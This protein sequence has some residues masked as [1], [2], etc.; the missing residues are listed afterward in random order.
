MS[1]K[2]IIS[3]I[4]ILLF[5]AADGLAAT[6]TVT[7]TNDSGPG[8]L[9]QAVL[10]ANASNDDDTIL[11]DIPDCPNA[12]CTIELTSGELGIGPNGKLKILNHGGPD[13]LII[14]GGNLSWIFLVDQSPSFIVQGLTMQRA[15]GGQ[16]LGPFQGGA[17]ANHLGKTSVVNCRLQH[18]IGLGGG[19]ANLN[20]SLE[21]IRS[22]IINNRSLSEGG[23]IFNFDGDLTVIDSLIAENV[24]GSKSL[25]GFGGGIMI[26]AMYDFSRIVTIANTTISRNTT[27]SP[28]GGG[29]GG[30]IYLLNANSTVNLINVT[31]T[32]NSAVYGGAVA[33]DGLFGSS[34]R[35]RNSIFSGNFADSYPEISLNTVY[36]ENLGNNLL[37]GSPM[38]GQLA[39]N[40]GPTRTHALLAGSPAI[41]AGND[42]VLTEN[43]CG[44]GNPSLAVDQRGRARRGNVDIGAFEQNPATSDFDGDGRSDI[45]V[46][47]PGNS[48]WYFLNGNGFS[49]R[50][51]GQSNDIPAPADYDG[52]GRSEMAVFR[53][54][55]GQWL[56][57]D[58][59]TQT[60]ATYNWGQQGDIPVAADHNGD[61]RADLV[62]FRPSNGIWYRYSVS[63]GP[64]GS[65]QFGVDGDQPINGDF[66]ADGRADTA[67]YR[68]SNNDWYIA[69]NSSYSVTTWG[70]AGDIPTPAD[71]DGDGVTDL[72]IFRPS[73]GRWYIRGS[74][75]G[76]RLVNWG[77]SGDIPVAAD[78]DGDGKADTAVFRPGNSTWYIVNSTNG[79]QLQPF[80]QNGD[81]PT[82]RAVTY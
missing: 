60:V 1:L 6:Y 41:N 64:F 28:E 69:T 24:A 31:V 75:D 35:A 61:G 2:A 53:P 25:D 70:E 81:I 56:V 62:V 67:V 71:F 39:N 22:E 48:S 26:F 32:E 68:P 9:R 54:S 55:T 30:G 18:N 12:V 19:V 76:I 29:Q 3:T 63:S 5:L 14:D 13:K 40:G 38:L 50:A 37:G 45:S 34:M 74:Q 80:G 49:V 59:S 73:T 10:D 72:A 51:F 16:K 11:F 47:R 36:A 44:D 42:C 58:S 79:M 23:G 78:Y 17:I 4:A 82:P 52:D 33:G 77:Q 43:G 21:I 66:D 46:Y 65:R 7:N 8:S 20:G 15:F 57:L 27:I